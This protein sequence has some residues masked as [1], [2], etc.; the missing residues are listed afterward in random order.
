TSFKNAPAKDTY[1]ARGGTCPRQPQPQFLHQHISRSGHQ[2]TELIGP[3]VRATGAPH[4]H[5]LMQLLDAVLEVSSLT[6][7]FLVNPLWTLL[8]VGNDEARIFLG[9]FAFA[10][11]HLA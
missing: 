1:C 4:L 8:H 9:L 3:E 2:D 7:N 6:V 10:A 5:A 11:H